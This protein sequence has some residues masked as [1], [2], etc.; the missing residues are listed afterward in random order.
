LLLPHPPRIAVL[1]FTLVDA[2]TSRPFRG[3]P[4]GVVVLDAPAPEGWMA[5]VAAEVNASE[6]AF[7]HPEGEAWRLR[8]FTPMVEVALCGHA[9]LAS[10]HVL[11]STG[12]AT[13]PLRFR[14]RSGVLGAATDDEDRIWLDLPAW[15]VLEHPT[16]SMLAGALPGIE[17]AYVGRTAGAQPNDVVEVGDEAT[18]LRVRPDLRTVAALGS[19]GLIVTAPGDGDTDLVSRYFAPAVGVDEDPVTG[20]AHSTLGPLWAERLGRHELT[21]RQVSSRGGELLIRVAGDRVQV[22]GSAITVITG[23]VLAP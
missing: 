17:H 12:R 11:W 8:W 1:P 23:E 14:T 7:V 20:T 10:A 9:T 19:T 3:N 4:A 21:A 13:G 2:F 6:T 5:S 22:G 16:P 15:P 18:L